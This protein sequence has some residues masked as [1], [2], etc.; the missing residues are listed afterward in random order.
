ML[1]DDVVALPRVGHELSY[2]HLAL[3]LVVN[4]PGAP[5]SLHLP[6]AAS[7]SCR[8]VYH[9]QSIEVAT[10]QAKRHFSIDSPQQR[11]LHDS[12]SLHMFPQDDVIT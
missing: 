9:I 8:I 10:C 1:F 3:G 5:K 12:H 4:G 6:I 11:V 7:N 2:R